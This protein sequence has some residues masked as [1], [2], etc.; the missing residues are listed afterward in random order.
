MIKLTYV[1]VEANAMLLLLRINVRIKN[2]L[3]TLINIIFI[4][5]DKIAELMTPLVLDS[6]KMIF[7]LYNFPWNIYL[8]NRTAKSYNFKCVSSFFSGP[9]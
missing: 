4:L 2:L 6:L 5:I 1:M 7:K 9:N 3:W 8:K